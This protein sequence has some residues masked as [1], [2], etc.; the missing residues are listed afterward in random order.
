[1]A[2]ARQIFN[3]IKS[4]KDSRNGR[5]LVFTGAR[6]VGKTTLVK[7]GLTDYTYLSIEDPVMRSA[8]TALSAPQWHTLYP[9]AALDEIQKEPRLI[10]SIKATYDQF[11]DV[12]YTLL[13]SSQLLLMKQ[14]KESLA[15]RCS[16]VEMFP[17][18]LP[19]LRT[20]HFD[21]AVQPSLWQAILKS[22]EIP[23]IL[24]SFLL[25]P[26]MAY[27]KKAFDHYVRF[28]GYPALTATD[29]TDDEKYRWLAGY[30]RTY[31]ERD[32]RDL[33]NFRELE[34]FV[35]LQQTL[36]IQTGTLFNASNLASRLGLSPKT[37][38]RYLT[39]LDMSYQTI[40]LVPWEKNAGKRLAKM[41][42]V[43]FMDNGVLQAVLQK[44]GGVSG[45]EF[46]SL[47]VAEI[48]KQSKNIFA[49]VKF[50]HLRTH[51]GKE[52]DLLAELSNGYVAFEIK[53]TDKVLKED[54]KHLLK[55]SDMLDK[56]LLHGF[57]LSNDNA[58]TRFSENVTAVH[59]A[60]FLG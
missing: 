14:V 37:V 46:E 59:V 44:K 36:A 11:E 33:A 12:R 42:K 48:Y 50:Y 25:D 57:V 9:K 41:P 49:P 53:M 35:K 32:I 27:K 21:A 51:D 23:E 24:P 22:G 40:T 60:Q 43:H 47:V 34:P 39:Y 45:A 56:P 26:D 13:G 7:R 58:V 28:G 30:V 10:E 38:Q 8:Y 29:M 20:E 52:I 16:I 2:K 55:L 4:L 18:T 6:Q 3:E 1:M 5:I 19:E 15:G 54:A 17:L 31:L